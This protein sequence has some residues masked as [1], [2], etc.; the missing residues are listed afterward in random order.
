MEIQGITTMDEEI[1]FGRCEIK[2]VSDK[3]KK[4]FP[5]QN[6]IEVI[7]NGKSY[8]LNTDYVIL[9]LTSLRES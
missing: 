5:N 3:I 6:L 7:E 9:F 4:L 8:I 2:E 1:S